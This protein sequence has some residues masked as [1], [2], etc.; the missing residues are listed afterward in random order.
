MS[1]KLNPDPFP[2][3]PRR[4]FFS[5]EPVAA[6]IVPPKASVPSDVAPAVTAIVPPPKKGT[7][8][9][10]RLKKQRQRERLKAARQALASHG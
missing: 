8:E 1:A 9:Y 6:P 10:E 3:L 2:H 4:S 7:A 5:A